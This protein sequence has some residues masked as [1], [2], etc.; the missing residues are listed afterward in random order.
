MYGESSR[1]I[2]N[3]VSI[4]SWRSWLDIAG[5]TK[6]A[7]SYVGKPRCLPTVVLPPIGPA[8]SQGNAGGG[9]NPRI[10]RSDPWRS[11]H[12]DDPKERSQVYS[13]QSGAWYPVNATFYPELG[14]YRTLRSHHLVTGSEE[15]CWRTIT[16]T[17]ST[18][19]RGSSG[20]VLGD[21]GLRGA[22]CF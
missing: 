3:R 14:L 10:R 15:E 16:A 11:S 18:H 2:T 5:G 13:D 4:P 21:V 7:D 17:R 8:F 19:P 20:A 6:S 12:L 9:S 1:F 22:A